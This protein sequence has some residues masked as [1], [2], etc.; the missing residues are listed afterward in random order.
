M[1]V[2]RASGPE[3]GGARSGEEVD[4]GCKGGEDLEGWRYHLME[5]APED[6]GSRSHRHVEWGRKLREFTTEFSRTERQPK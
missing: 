5:H 3:V 2:W 4:G 6:G 1:V